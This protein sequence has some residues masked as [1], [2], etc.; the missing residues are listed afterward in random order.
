LSVQRR[1][2]RRFFMLMCFEATATY[3]AA[4]AATAY[5]AA[6][7]RERAQAHMPLPARAERFQ[8]CC[9]RCPL[10]APALPL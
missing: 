7:G 9:C 2:A 3:Y 6:S 10:K 4:R 8:P 1:H 5:A